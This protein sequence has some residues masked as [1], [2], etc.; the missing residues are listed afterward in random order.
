MLAKENRLS[1]KKDFDN[2]FQFGRSSYNKILGVKVVKNNLNKN[3]FGVIV[4]N[5][6]S[7]KAV[8]R[9]RLKRQIKAILREENQKLKI[10]FDCVIISLPAILEVD[11]NQIKKSIIGRFNKL[12]LYKR[13]SV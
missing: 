11:F 2:V 13:K 4:S 10:G 1:K 5:K 8:V 9:N 3:R 6:I 12:R 7:K